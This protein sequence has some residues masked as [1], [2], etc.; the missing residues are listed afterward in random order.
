MYLSILLVCCFG[1]VAFLKR[2]I[3]LWRGMGFVSSMLSGRDDLPM[4]KS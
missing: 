1:G 3:F 2:L 4:H